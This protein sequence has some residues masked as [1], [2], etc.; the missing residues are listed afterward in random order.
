MSKLIEWEMN[1]RRQENCL[2]SRI[3]CGVVSVY[4]QS[5]SQLSFILYPMNLYLSLMK[6]YE[7]F[8]FEFLPQ[9]DCPILCGINP[10]QICGCQEKN[11]FERRRSKKMILSF[12]GFLYMNK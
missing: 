7:E 8:G 11:I 6:I 9:F 4:E 2:S 3:D 1:E 5:I 10:V 12:L